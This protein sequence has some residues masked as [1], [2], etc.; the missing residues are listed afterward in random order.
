MHRTISKPSPSHKRQTSVFSVPKENIE[1]PTP[2]FS[3]PKRCFQELSNK[4]VLQ[5]DPTSFECDESIEDVKQS[6][7]WKCETIDYYKS[8]EESVN[9]YCPV[10]SYLYT[11]QPNITAN[12]RAILLDWMMEVCAEFTL[13]RETFHMAVSHLDRFLAGVGPI[14][15]NEFQLVGLVAMYISAK[16]EEIFPPKLE[17]WVKSADEGYSAG[18]IKAME[19]YMLRCMH[20]TVHPPTVFNYLNWLMT[21]W[22]NFISFHFSCVLFNNLSDFK[23]LLPEDRNKHQKQFERRMILFKAPNQQAYKRYRETLQVLDTSALEI[24]SILPKYMASGLLYLMVSKYFFESNYELLY[25]NGPD[26]SP[27]NKTRLAMYIDENG[28]QLT[29]ADYNLESSSHVQELFSSFIAASLGVQ[30]IDEIYEAVKYLHPIMEIEIDYSLPVVC[31]TKTKSN[32]ERH[33]GEFLTFQTHTTKNLEFVS[34]RIKGQ[35]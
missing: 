24:T 6:S 12:M 1:E 26:F 35:S 16:I 13:K 34:R 28:A 7:V 33:Y 8:L 31:R 3:H 9:R 10:P 5:T 19:L 21:Q 11:S 29:G 14:Q 17:D 15:K 4:S 22:D 32:L 25:F 20:W 18:M 27:K 30:S 2:V 23:S